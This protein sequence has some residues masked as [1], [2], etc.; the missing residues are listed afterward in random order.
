MQIDR[1]LV[2]RK[3]KAT[4]LHVGL[5]LV[6]FLPYLYLLIYVWF[7]GPL[8]FTDGGW[9][10][11][12]LMLLCDV[13]LGPILTFLVFNPKK[14]RRALGFDFSLI[15]L[16]QLGALA[17][18][19]HAVLSQRPVAVSLSSGLFQA[20]LP[21]TLA[22][23]E[24]APADWARLGAGKPYWVFRREA[25]NADERAGVVT[26]A[27]LEN[28]GEEGLFFLFEPLK[29]SRAGIEAAKID[30][31]EWIKRDAGLESQFKAIEERQSG[32]LIWLHLAGRYADA[33]IAFDA[34]LNQV[35]WIRR[36]LE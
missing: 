30:K 11:L 23:Q 28:V 7:P 20:V 33:L 5:S 19:T 10:G 32:P 21:E 8:F 17:Y 14:S 4:A 36:E 6:I 18:G 12:R 27:M 13:V 1:S 3:L 22:K 2:F 35:G 31:T 24:I 15:A 9:Q 34:D 16:A 26:F 25:K 29:D